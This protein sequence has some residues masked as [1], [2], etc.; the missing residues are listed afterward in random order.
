MTPTV[1]DICTFAVISLVTRPFCG[2]TRVYEGHFMLYKDHAVAKFLEVIG[3]LDFYC[4]LH[5]A[6]LSLTP[7]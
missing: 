1:H 5:V 4:Y 6:S 2:S 3:L 7:L